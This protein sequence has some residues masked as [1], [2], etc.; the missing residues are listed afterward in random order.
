MGMKFRSNSTGPALA[1]VLL[2]VAIGTVLTIL[3][4]MEVV[5]AFFAT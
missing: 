1:L 5:R 2:L 3:G 4:L